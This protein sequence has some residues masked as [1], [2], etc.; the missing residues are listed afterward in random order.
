MRQSLFGLAF[1]VEPGKR[2]LPDRQ[3]PLLYFK[4]TKKFLYFGNVAEL[5]VPE[6]ALSS[7]C[8]KISS[9]DNVDPIVPVFTEKIAYKLLDRTIRFKYFS[10]DQ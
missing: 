8:G 7:K 2:G 10:T 4:I 1:Q 9:F 3:M 5:A 6:D